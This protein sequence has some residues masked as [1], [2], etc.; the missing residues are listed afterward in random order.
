MLMLCGVDYVEVLSS[1]VVLFSCNLMV[2]GWFKLDRFTNSWTSL[3][4]KLIYGM[5]FY[6][7]VVNVNGLVWV[8]VCDASGV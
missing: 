5:L 8:V 2:E 7:I 4:V 3:V 6:W 1:L